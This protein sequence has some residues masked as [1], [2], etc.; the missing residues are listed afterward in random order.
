[1]NSFDDLLIDPRRGVLEAAVYDAA[2]ALRR[3]L[4]GEPG[5]AEV[6]LDA[7]QRRQLEALWAELE[8]QPAGYREWPTHARTWRFST[9]ANLLVIWWRDYLGRRHVRV[10]AGCAHKDP[11][12]P[13]PGPTRPPLAC[14]YPAHAVIVSQHRRCRLLV[15]CGCGAWGTP[16][17]VAWM[18]K[19]CGPCYDR[20]QDEAV[21]PLGWQASAAAVERLAFSPDGERLATLAASG[22]VEVRELASGRPLA[23]CA[24]GSSTKSIAWEPGRHVLAVGGSWPREG[25]RCEEDQGLRALPQPFVFLP[26]GQWV[27]VLD[28]NNHPVLLDGESL[29]PVRRFP[30]SLSARIEALAVSPDGHLLAG[31][32][33]EGLFFWDVRAAWA[34]PPLRLGPCA[35]PLVFS[36]DGALVAVQARAAFPHVVLVN[37]ARGRHHATLGASTGAFDFAF[38]PDGAVIATVGEETLRVW[39]VK[40]GEERRSLSLGGEEG[41]RSVAFTPDGRL[42]ALGTSAGHVRVWPAEILRAE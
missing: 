4:R 25:A 14:V 2:D 27:I 12:L 23:S 38:S 13:M 10:V 40:S 30:S 11:R 6:Q 37:A 39:D 17:E 26:E 5:W 20:G 8:G 24:F 16:A 32:T 18:G 36:P 7:C 21:A 9:Q 19:C 41:L 31:A 28:V 1:M 35:A 42:L 22:E 15:V 3:E 34:R 29:E 33:E